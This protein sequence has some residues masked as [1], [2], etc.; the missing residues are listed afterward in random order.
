MRKLDSVIVELISTFGWTTYRKRS[1]M[2][3]IYL[4]NKHYGQTVELSLDLFK[5]LYSCT[6]EIYQS[7]LKLINSAFSK[8]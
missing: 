1:N 6:G 4:K 5:G 7:D 2:Y 8:V 3:H